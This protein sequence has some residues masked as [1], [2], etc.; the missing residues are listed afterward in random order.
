VTDEAIRCR[1]TVPHSDFIL[2]NHRVHGVSVMPGVTFADILFRILG[3]RGFDVSR[4]TL[5]DIVFPRPLATTAHLDRDVL[6]IIQGSQ[7]SIASR[8][9]CEGGGGDDWTRHL[10]GRLALEDPLEDAWLDVDAWK[11]SSHQVRDMAELYAQARDE[12]IVHGAAMRCTGRLFLRDG[13][14]LAELET[15]PSTRAHDGK[16]HLPPAAL[17]AST[18]VAFARTPALDAPFIPIAL[19]SLRAPVAM[20]G[21][22]YV[23]VPGEEQL[24]S[25]RDVMHNSYTIHDAAGRRIAEFTRL[26]CKRIRAPHAITSLVDG[27][28]RPDDRFTR[29]LRSL[30]GRVLKLPPERVSATVGFYELGLDSAAML[31]ISQELE[32]FVGSPL[33]PTLL[34][35]YSNIAALARHLEGTHRG[36]GAPP[37]SDEI[38]AFRRVWRPVSPVGDRPLTGGT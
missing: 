38:T 19:A 2:Q 7:I 10:T 17:D 14:L 27:A 30:V 37:L 1:L 36:A 13:G 25:S 16:F 5:R 24:A 29:Q 9:I 31:Q 34:F 33:Y 8:P 21:R 35:E 15:D 3:A 6:V 22:F 11:A 4:V 18:L 12:A 20:A 26:T 32:S 23:H 28:A